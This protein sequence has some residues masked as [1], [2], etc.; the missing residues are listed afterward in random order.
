VLAAFFR[1]G[2]L[3]VL[4]ALAASIAHTIDGHDWLQ[5][6]ALHLLFLGGI[7]QLVLGAGQ[8]FVCAFLATDPPPQRLIWAQL[9]A[10]NVAESGRTEFA[11]CRTLPRRHAIAAGLLRDVQRLVCVL[12]ALNGGEAGLDLRNT[13][14]DGDR[15]VSAAGATRTERASHF[16]PSAGVGAARRCASPWTARR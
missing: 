1:A 10:W 11:T 14:R 5:W 3:F 7:S 4:A 8:F 16:H 9:A 12:D 13:D 6:L 2:L 15:D